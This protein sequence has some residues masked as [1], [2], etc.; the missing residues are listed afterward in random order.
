MQ[1]SFDYTQLLNYFHG[2]IAQTKL[3]HEIRKKKKSQNLVKK[4]SIQNVAHI[5]YM[6]RLFDL[7]ELNEFQFQGTVLL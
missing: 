2:N 6:F 7:G 3:I 5:V 1:K 4:M